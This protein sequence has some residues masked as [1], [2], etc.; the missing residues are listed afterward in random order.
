M[1][2]FALVCLALLAAQGNQPAAGEIARAIAQLGAAE[3]AAR[4]AATD[5][6]WKAGEAAEGPLREAA[7]NTDPEVRT[8]AVSLLSKLR[9][10][11]RPETPPDVV[12]LIDQFRYTNDANQRRQAIAQ[13][14]VKGYWQAIFALIRSENDSQQRRV[15]AAVVATDASK[16]I[17]PLLDRGD[18]AQAEEFLELLATSD[19][20]L[21][22]FIAFLILSDLLDHHIDLLR[23]R[24]AG[25]PQADDWS[26]LAMLLRA[27][28]DQS[29][30]I[31]AAAKTQD[32]I[33]QAN[34]FAEA[35]RWGEAGAVAEQIQQ[36]NPQRLDTAAFAAS[37]YR[38]A[39]KSEDHERIVS[40]LL[41][42]A[43]LDRLKENPPAER[44]VDPFG[45]RRRTWDWP[46]PGRPSRRC[47]STSGLATP[48]RSCGRSIRDSRTPF[49]GGSI[50]TPRRWS[51]SA[52]PM[53]SR[54]TGRGSTR[55]QHHRARQMPSRSSD[56]CWQCRW[57]G[58]FASWGER[59]MRSECFPNH[60]I[61]WHRLPATGRGD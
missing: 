20:G 29:A 39:E 8:R 1:L 22:Q 3:F 23:T 17:R 56:F 30:A 58:S 47:W 21:S 2:A 50:A 55:C 38:L 37:F 7:R 49:C 13:L 31:E 46:T 4:E 53:I 59:R 12:L 48:C 33:L 24:L 44:P 32:L 27:K 40:S 15:L 19:A 34:L 5:L 28:G 10:G 57:R 61:T 54:W 25:Q 41:K 45:E 36:R 6:L 52:S 9:L 26:R 14:Q 18:T 11:V 51:L 16:L 35:R 42:A 60:C 43:N